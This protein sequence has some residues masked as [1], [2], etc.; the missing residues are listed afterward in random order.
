MDFSLALFIGDL[1][2]VFFF[3]LSGAL[4]AA[5]RGYDIIGSLLL[6]ALTGMGGGIVRD[7]IL[8]VHPPA[9]FA[10]PWYLLPP[11]LA[12]A[13]VY[14]FHRQISAMD[15]TLIYCDALGLGLFC[16]TGTLKA[17][18]HGFEPWAA[19]FM[20]VITAAGGGVLRDVVANTVPTVIRHD[21]IYVVPAL[22]GS[23]MVAVFFMLDVINVW[24]STFAAIVAIILR[25]L[26]VEFKWTVP[27]AR[28]P[29]HSQ[30]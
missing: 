17:L 21:N 12:S 25:I 1:L 27:M 14:L 9:A 7:V 30:G 2:G 11:V 19:V 24:T 15:K 6:G 10:N 18:H 20:G 22:L 13:I 29:R 4:L 26:A 28:H 3:A 16:V 5:D 8:G 23:V